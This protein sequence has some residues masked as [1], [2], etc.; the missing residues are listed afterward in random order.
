[1]KEMKKVEKEK[2]K[3]KNSEINRIS[4]QKI[5]KNKKTLDDLYY[6]YPKVVEC[7]ETK[8]LLKN[9]QINKLVKDE[10]EKRKNDKTGDAFHFT[11]K[12]EI[13]NELNKIREE[14]CKG[15]ELEKKNKHYLGQKI[16][17]EKLFFSSTK[18]N[19]YFI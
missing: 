19:E 4:K 18:V 12:E 13:T 8:R 17:F 7:I 9:K 10:V 6:K 5:Q 11:S 14:I 16:Y 2:S 3:K 1:M 15:D